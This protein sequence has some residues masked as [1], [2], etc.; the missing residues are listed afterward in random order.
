MYDVIGQCA[1]LL[2]IREGCFE[3]VGLGLDIIGQSAELLGVH[4]P[5]FKVICLWFEL[6]GQHFQVFCLTDVW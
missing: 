6:V 1:E 4:L 3:V 2:G 5:R